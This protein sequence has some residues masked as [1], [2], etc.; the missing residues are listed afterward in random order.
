MDE[1]VLKKLKEIPG[2]VRGVTMQTDANYVLR[3]IGEEGL[4]KLQQKT[5]QLGWEIDYKHIKTMGW[6]PLGQRVV[7]LLAAKETFGWGD[8]EIQDMGNC[9]PKYSFI[10][11]TMLKYFLSV[12]KVFQEAARYWDKHYSVG[13]LVPVKIDEKNKFALL[14]LKDFNVDPVFCPYFTGYFLR[15]SQMVIKSE[16]ITAEE[17]ECPSKGGQWHEFLMKWV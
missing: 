15:I 5:K 3:K 9:A 12:S 10:A 4:A 16:K 11:S 13:K 6:Y 14:R 1:A 17:T 7:S 8:K 2:E